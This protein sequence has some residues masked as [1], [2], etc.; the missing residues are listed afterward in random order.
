METEARVPL[1]S[2][3]SAWSPQFKVSQEYIVIPFLKI[4]EEKNEEC[5]KI[6]SSPLTKKI[7]EVY[8]HFY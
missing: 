3:R 4:R 1:L 8:E 2:L 7:F 6:F 5:L